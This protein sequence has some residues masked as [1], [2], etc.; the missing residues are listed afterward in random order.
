MTVS[1]RQV[2]RSRRVEFPK[3]LVMALETMRE[4]LN[5]QREGKAE[6]MT[7]DEFIA[8]RLTED[9]TE[10]EFGTMK[11]ELPSLRVAMEQYAA[12]QAE[13]IR[14]S[15]RRKQAKLAKQPTRLARFMA[16]HKVERRTLSSGRAVSRRHLHELISGT[17]TSPTLRMMVEVTR[18]M[19]RL[20]GRPVEI[21][22]LF[23]LAVGD[24][25]E[26]R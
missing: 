6:P 20:T 1:R 25:D 14:E 26:A 8:W 5:L 9:I 3:F 15:A 16:E 7:F 21:A 17:S 12:W 22:D 11:D 10:D 4:M 23:D 18:E 24:G 2:F 13:E 19:R